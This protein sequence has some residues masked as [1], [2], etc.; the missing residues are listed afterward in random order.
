MLYALKL[1]YQINDF[2]IESTGPKSSALAN[3]VTQLLADGVPIDGVGLQ[4]HLVVGQVPSTFQSNLQAFA[5]LGVE[6][7]I[8][9]LDIRMTLPETPDQLAQQ[10][11]DYKTVIAACKAVSGCVGVTLWDWTDKVRSF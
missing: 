1:H 4:T 10:A 6:V 9:E 7:A 2:G 5:D 8:T 11:V 3:L